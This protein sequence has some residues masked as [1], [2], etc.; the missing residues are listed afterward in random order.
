MEVGGGHG[1]VLEHV[2]GD[3]DG[4]RIITQGK[5]DLSSPHGVG[6][7]EDTGMLDM[8]EGGVHACGLYLLRLVEL[9]RVEGAAP[10]PA[11]GWTEGRRA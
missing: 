1:G 5:E 4:L 3:A 6:L 10:V 11:I 8:L 7:K 9:S 2:P